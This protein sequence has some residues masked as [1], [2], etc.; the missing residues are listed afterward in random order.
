MID[1]NYLSYIIMLKKLKNRNTILKKCVS[2]IISQN[3][4]ELNTYVN[5]FNHIKNGSLKKMN[6]NLKNKLS[7]YKQS[8]INDKIISVDNYIKSINKLSKNNPP[9]KSKIYNRRFSKLELNNLSAN[10]LIHII[11][12]INKYQYSNI[13]MAL[14][15]I[16]SNL[17]K[18]YSKTKN[19]KIIFNENIN[20]VIDLKKKEMINYI[21]NN[22][23]QSGSGFYMDLESTVVGGLPLLKGYVE[24]NPPVFV[25]KLLPQTG[26]GYYYDFGKGALAGRP[27][28]KGY[29]DHNPPLFMGDLVPKVTVQ[30]R[31]MIGGGNNNIDYKIKHLNNYIQGGSYSK[32]PSSIKKDLHNL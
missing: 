29:D 5:Q 9:K 32:L 26:N 19:K 12:D 3:S 10:D 21:L 1:N 18:K 14:V 16:D 20:T 6:N 22:T 8:V 15:N 30:D 13:I 23:S 28:T 27:L 17:L 11:A 4:N 24:R 7:S 25:D 2:D 31:K